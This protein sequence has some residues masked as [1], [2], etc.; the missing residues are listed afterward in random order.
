MRTARMNSAFPVG[1]V[2]PPP[3]LDAMTPAKVPLNP[4]PTLAHLPNDLWA[5]TAPAAVGLP[6]QPAVPYA[7]LQSGRSGEWCSGPLSAPTHPDSH[8]LPAYAA[9]PP[10][11]GEWFNTV[12]S[13]AANLNKQGLEQALDILDSAIKNVQ[14]AKAVENV[15]AASA[16]QA[17]S[18]FPSA[19]HLVA[20]ELLRTQVGRDQRQ[21]LHQLCALNGAAPA[22]LQQGPAA[23]L[24][25]SQ[26]LAGA[27][28][29]PPRRSPDTKAGPWP[30]GGQL[31]AAKA[32]A[33]RQPQ[34][35][36]TSLQ[37]LSDEDPACLFIVRRINKLGFKASRKLKQHFA[38]YGHVVRVLVA[39][40]TVRQHGDP[41]CYARCRPSS[42]GFV[43]MASA[44]AV[45]CVLEAGEEQEVD[46]SLIR[47]QRFERQRGDQVLEEDE[48]EHEEEANALEKMDSMGWG[49]QHTASTT[50][51]AASFESSDF[52]LAEQA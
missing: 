45:R 17:G 8:G 18:A 48:E 11:S 7:P 31:P 5:G 47:V 10:P 15:I 22:G 30:A 3:G 9:Q 39:H 51:T 32:L 49:R 34:T 2:M 21:L 43:H 41:E 20:A 25:E 24:L 35:L 16:R 14:Y 27:P 38:A 4:R 6:G 33:G 40:S 36:S 29:A 28:P 52:L 13:T 23:T 19:P 1:A 46:G 12:R 50:A 44:E 26:L 37:L 42:L